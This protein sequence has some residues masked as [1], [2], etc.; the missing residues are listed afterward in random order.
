M[1]QQQGAQALRQVLQGQAL[2]AQGRQ[3]L[4]KQGQVVLQLLRES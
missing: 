1:V 2:Q 4:R 3:V